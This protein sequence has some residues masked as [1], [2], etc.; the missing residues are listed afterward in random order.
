LRKNFPKLVRARSSP[1]SAFPPRS[2]AAGVLAPLVTVPSTLDRD[3][4]L[5]IASIGRRVS[6]NQPAKRHAAG[7]GPPWGLGK[8]RGAAFG[9]YGALGAASACC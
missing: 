9:L 6:T 8:E 1:P 5:A 4:Y 3:N 7:P 2:T